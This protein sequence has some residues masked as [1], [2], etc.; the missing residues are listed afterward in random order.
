M[1]A[2]YTEIIENFQPAID[3]AKDIPG[4]TTTFEPK[5]KR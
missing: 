3:P 2:D 4:K 1:A 5:F